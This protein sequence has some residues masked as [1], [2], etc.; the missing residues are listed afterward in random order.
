MA[1]CVLSCTIL[2]CSVTLLTVCSVT[3]LYVWFHGRTI[4]VGIGTAASQQTQIRLPPFSTWDMQ[5][6]SR[7]WISVLYHTPICN[8][9]TE[10]LRAGLISEA[11]GLFPHCR[12]MLV[13]QWTDCS[14]AIACGHHMV[15]FLSPFHFFSVSHAQT[16]AQESGDWGLM[17]M[18]RVRIL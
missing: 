4:W 15:L 14:F 12:R 3:V 9:Y 17:L 6:E 8:N 18:H 10:H 16:H 5:T 7:S 2:L 11:N 13:I 1:P